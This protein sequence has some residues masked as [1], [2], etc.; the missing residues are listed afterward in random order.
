M[1]SLLNRKKML[2]PIRS[3]LQLCLPLPQ[4]YM[5]IERERGASV[6]KQ[7]HETGGKNAVSFLAITGDTA[8][9]SLPSLPVLLVDFFRK[10]S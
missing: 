8:T 9:D 1:P 5:I 2:L 6:D 7:K 10:G 4:Q 3:S